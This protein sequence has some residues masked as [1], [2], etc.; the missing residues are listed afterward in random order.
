MAE[1]RPRANQT[2]QCP[3][4][5]AVDRPCWILGLSLGTVRVSKL[6]SLC[7]NRGSRSPVDSVDA[8]RV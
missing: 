3:K 6:A 4:G 5:Y 1:N 2:F 8:L 7:A